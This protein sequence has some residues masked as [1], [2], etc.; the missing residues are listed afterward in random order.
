MPLLNQLIQLLLTK[1]ANLLGEDLG[2]ILSLKLGGSQEKSSTSPEEL[3]NFSIFYS[4]RRIGILFLSVNI[5]EKIAKKE[6]K[7]TN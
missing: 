6:Y 5:G 2:E 3:E 7:E 1:L 4:R